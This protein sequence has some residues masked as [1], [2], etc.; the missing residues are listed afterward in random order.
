MSTPRPISALAYLDD[1]GWWTIKIP[2]LTSP[3][4]NGRTIT[5]TG[6]A[7]TFRAI[8]KA[9]RELA[10][11]WLDLDD[12]DV[13]VTVEVVIPDNIAELWK[14]GTHAEESARA[15]QARAVGLRRQAVRALRDKGYPA[16]AAAA[17]LGVSRQR[18]DQLQKAVT[19]SEAG[20]TLA[21]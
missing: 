14:E 20:A 2:S 4:P 3:G 5:A 11:A 10:T 13:S 9:A 6:A 7:T 1:D 8:D 21:S 18:I 15:E 19:V 12:D 16:E 17:A